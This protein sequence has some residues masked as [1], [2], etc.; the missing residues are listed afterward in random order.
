MRVRPKIN[1]KRSPPHN[2]M[3]NIFSDFLRLILISKNPIK[4]FNSEITAPISNDLK[5]IAE[6]MEV[7]YSIVTIRKARTEIEKQTISNCLSFFII[8]GLQYR[9]NE[10]IHPCKHTKE[11]TNYCEHWF[12]F[13]M[14]IQPDTDENHYRYGNRQ[15][16]T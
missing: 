12:S 16:K 5:I 14:T 1:L 3:R 13:K 4:K 6:M 9:F 15:L 2:E 11:C 10:C 7:K 8:P